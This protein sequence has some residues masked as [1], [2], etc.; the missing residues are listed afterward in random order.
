MMT[1]I[2]RLCR[3]SLPAASIKVL[4]L[5]V[6]AAMPL[7][8]GPSN[9]AIVTRLSGVERLQL[10]SLQAMDAGTLGEISRVIDS[11]GIVART[12]EL[13]D[14]DVPAIGSRSVGP[15][16]LSPIHHTI[17]DAGKA[18][19]PHGLKLV[20]TLR[21]Q[22]TAPVSLDRLMD[23]SL[24]EDPSRLV[25][26]DTVLPVHPLWPNGPMPSLAPAGGLEGRLVYCGSGQWDDLK[27][28]PLPGS[29]A[30]L[31]FR[32]AGQMERLFSLGAKAVVVLEDG[33]VQYE[34]ATYLFTQTPTAFPRFYADAAIKEQLMELTGPDGIGPFTTLHGGQIYE[35][36]PVESIFFHLPVEDLQTYSVPN[37]LLIGW[38]AAEY[39]VN[40][41]DLFVANNLDGRQPAPGEV[42]TIPGTGRTFTVPEDGLWEV[43]ARLQDVDVTALKTANPEIAGQPLTEGMQVTLPAGQL[44]LAILVAIDTASVV[45][46]LPHGALAMANVAA[47]LELMEFLSTSPNLRLRRDVVF[48]FI[49]G[50]SL[51][52]QGSRLVA[53]YSYLLDN[54]FSSGVGPQRT[55]AG[56][57]QRYQAGMEWFETGT[58]PEEAEIRRWLVDDWLRPRF[59][60]QRILLAEDRIARIVESRGSED[61]PPLDV[62]EANLARVAELRDRTV[63]SGGD[64]TERLAQLMEAWAGDAAGDLKRFNLGKARLMERFRKEL[65]EEELT[66]ANHQ[67]NLATARKLRLATLDSEAPGNQFALGWK[68]NL[69]DAAPHL[70]LGVTSKSSLQLREAAGGAA[71]KRAIEPRMRQVAAFAA[72]KA[73]WPSDYLFIS[74][75]DRA[76]LSLLESPTVAGYDEFWA[77]ANYQVIGMMGESDRRNRVDTPAD[78]LENIAWDNLKLQAR[79]AFTLIASGLE[80]ILDT[81]IQETVRKKDLSRVGGLAVQFNI[82][83]GIDAKD[84]VP[85]AT[86]FLPMSK[87]QSADLNASAFF[88]YRRGIVQQTLLNGSFLM[89]VEDFSFNPKP[90]IYAYKLD[91]EQALF[92]KV[93]TQGQVGTKPQKNEFKY[94]IGE[95]VEKNLV[96]I[97]VYPRVFFIGSNPSTYK[98]I[99][100]GQYSQNVITLEDAV[101]QGNPR[102]FAIDNPI[103]DFKEKER[104]AVTLYMPPGDRVRA[105]IQSG[106]EYLFILPGPIEINED[107]EARGLGFLVGPDPATGD[108]NLLL[109]LTPHAIASGMWKLAK[110]RLEIYERYGIS[111][112]LLQTAVESSEKL[113][114]EAEQAIAENDW[115]KAIGSS[116]EAWGILVKNFPRVLKLGR[117]AVFS[118]ILLMALAV[119]GAWFLERLIIGS[120]GIVARLG[121]ITAIF[122]AATLFLNTFHPAFQIALSPF[123]IVIAFTMILMSVIVIALSYGRFQVVLQKFR[124]AGGEI[125]GEE[126]SFMSSLATA[127]SLGISN[128]KKRAFRTALTTFTVTVLTFS[129]VGF[130]AVKGQDSLTRMPQPIDNRVEGRVVDPLPPAYN[131]LLIRSHNWRGASEAKVAALQAEFGANF[132]VTV[133]AAYME[134]EGGNSANREGVN[135]ILVRYNGKESVLNAITLFQPNE[136][137]FSGLNRAVS[138]NTWFSAGDPGKGI[139]PDREKVI[140]P[141][142]IAAQLGIDPDQLTDPEGNLLPDD[143]LPVVELMNRSW[144]VIGILDTQ[145][146]N[147]IRD[148]NGRSLA[149]VDFLLSGM[150][151]NTSPGELVTEGTSYHMDWARLAIVPYAAR[152]DIQATPRSVAVKIPEGTDVDDV[153]QGMALRLKTEF[154]A[155]KDGEVSMV[156]PRAK[157]D[158]AGVAK[159]FLPVVLC[160]LIVMNTMLGTVEE[161]KGEVGMLGAIG[162]SPRQIAFLMFSE[163]T[164]F[165]ILGILFDTFG[166][167]LFANII[168]TINAG[169]GSVLTGLSFNFTS[170]ISMTLA[171]GT[172][173]VVLMATL[174]PANKAAALAAPSGMTEWELPED[175]VEGEINFRLPFTLTRGNAVGMTAF[176]HQF[177]VNHNEPTSEDFNCREVVVTNGVNDGHPYI[178]IRTDMWLA[179]Y[180]LDVAQHFTML[181]QSG[182]RENV[183]VV[184]LH[185]VRFSGSADNGRRTA[186]SL[187]NLIRKQFLLWRNLEPGRR[188]EFIAK[189]AE[190]MKSDSGK[191]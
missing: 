169:G 172:G 121:G 176:F 85:G 159:V 15:D 12:R 37:G 63:L 69:A 187:L 1:L 56:V 140:L 130:V 8:A 142:T 102:D 42:L 188:T 40:R 178:E 155:A 163:S 149:L 35:N 22:V 137:E 46:D 136:P 153:L 134:E 5:L 83:S 47:A 168:N 103:V 105:S 158:L 53:E 146:A 145:L 144:M 108:R 77:H 29:I 183:F 44:P 109:P 133:R 32:G 65:R 66:Q 52:G 122:I 73:G 41:N 138:N 81:R 58:P 97:D 70:G 30:L 128:L 156:I 116:R 3:K 177:L 72:S 119:P 180:D 150:A 7:S 147:R 191:G 95:V 186:Y 112:K 45:P 31:E 107:G 64:D 141:D 54:S 129:I 174:I 78:R 99:L 126:I 179:P 189:G 75:E 6:P 175:E 18:L 181:L 125:E 10:D 151:T 161:R 171:T 157:V 182:V 94:R 152:K 96:M 48:G 115:Q 59:E 114:Q 19:E 23:E 36:R 71:F 68:L 127:F 76:S 135:Q 166:G 90:R 167:L 61:L 84:P 165:S 74:Q 92:T 21:K 185:M 20:G 9:E 11:G 111:S 39:G 33:F 88:G 4:A 120:K 131:G 143:Q 2:Q 62:L 104:E 13:L 57:L 139:L 184:D 24:R 43:V 117:E 80:S 110:N 55:S 89:P 26:G 154:F 123:I 190:M 27:G 148:V 17:L 79:T 51:G 91:R 98:E 82:R 16:G 124:S 101:I 164:V 93:A 38:V 49:D 118:V 106:L 160:I 87:K 86:V 162:L 132:P 170:M 25:V 113:I 14:L 50:D 28:K 34:N 60:E 100:G 67:H 173:L